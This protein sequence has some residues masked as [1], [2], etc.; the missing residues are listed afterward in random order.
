MNDR[1]EAAA[2]VLHGDIENWWSDD[3]P[4]WE[5]VAEE[6]RERVRKWAAAALLAADAAE[7][8][9][10]PI[11]AAARVL[12]EAA[13]EAHAV[14]VGV[15]DSTMMLDIEG[16]IRQLAPAIVQMEVALLAADAAGWYPIET[17]PKEPWQPIDVWIEHSQSGGR[18][19]TDVRRGHFA[20]WFDCGGNELDWSHVDPET[21][22][23]VTSRV[24]HWMPL[25]APPEH[26]P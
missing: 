20:E 21:G 7:R 8:E 15:S 1:I 10:Q 18:R 4:T 9:W 13:S 6:A 11:E 16:A 24:T 22:K 25:P 12:L 26:T 14:L 19:E 2:R 17:A 3:P 23:Q 5:S